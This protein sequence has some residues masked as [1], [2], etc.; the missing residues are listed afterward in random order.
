MANLNPLSLAP[1]NVLSRTS[2]V[3][4]R[5]TSLQLFDAVI[6]S[7][8]TGLFKRS[9]SEG[10]NLNRNLLQ[11]GKEFM[12]ELK[13]LANSIKSKIL[14]RSNVLFKIQLF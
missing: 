13:V 3:L 5:T 6:K 4:S 2:N 11:K 7:A 9:H 10:T 8:A 14:T 12:E 1:A